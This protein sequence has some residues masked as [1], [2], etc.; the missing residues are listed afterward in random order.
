MAISAT[1]GAEHTIDLPQGTVAYREHGTGTPVLLVHG[2]LCNGDLWREV[3]PALDALGRYRLITPDLPMGSHTLRLRPGTDVT[4]PGIVALIVALLDGLGLDRVVVVANDAGG[5]ISQMLAA[6]H[7]ERIDRLVLTSCDTFGQF[8]PRYLKPL[9]WLAAIPRLDDLIARSFAF[10]VV[11]GP[12]FW[13]VAHTPLPPAIRRSYLGPML[14]DPVIRADLMAFF[15]GTRPRHTLRAARG[16]RRFDRP[17]LI[18]WAFD[19][20]WFARRNGRRL[21]RTIPDARFA[22][23]PGARTFVPEDAPKELAARVHAFLTETEAR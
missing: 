7:P 21:A 22:V 8:P 9:R 1:L 19:D 13:S 18:L 14:E 23:I 12:F 2:G 4:P 5:A 10:R 15:R 16:L 3:V 17:T 11:H 6:A 20:L